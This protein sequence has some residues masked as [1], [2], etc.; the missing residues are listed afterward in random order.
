MTLPAVLAIGLD[1]RFADFSTMPQLAPALIRAYIEAEIQRVREAG[2]KVQMLLIAPGVEPE[3]DARQ[4]I[5]TPMSH[6]AGAA[7]HVSRNLER[8]RRWHLAIS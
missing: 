6:R 7:R 2:F 1:P 5:R 8:R 3:A 4:K